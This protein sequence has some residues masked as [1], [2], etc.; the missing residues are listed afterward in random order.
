VSTPWSLAPHPSSFPRSL[1]SWTPSSMRRPRDTRGLRGEGRGG[2]S[3]SLSWGKAAVLDSDWGIWW[4]LM[5]CRLNAWF[6]PTVIAGLN[7]QRGGEKL[8]F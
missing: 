4:L 6:F 1:T 7:N 3:G 8:L 5:E 2:R